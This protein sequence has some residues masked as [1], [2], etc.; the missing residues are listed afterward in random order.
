MES[1]LLVDVIEEL[2]VLEMVEGVEE[3]VGSAVRGSA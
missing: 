3:V 1:S 2:G